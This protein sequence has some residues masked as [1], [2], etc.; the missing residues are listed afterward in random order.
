[1]KLGMF[2]LGLVVLEEEGDCN[3]SGGDWGKC[4]EY[5]EDIVVCIDWEI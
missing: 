1:M 2:F 5:F 4:F 3:F